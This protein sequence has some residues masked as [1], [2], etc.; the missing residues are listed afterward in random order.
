[1]KRLLLFTVAL[2]ALLALVLAYQTAARDREYRALLGHG[3]TAL[4]EDQTY[5]AIEAF[6]GAIALRPDSTIAHLRRGE[7]YRRRG[8]LAAAARDFRQAAE[9]DRAAVRP[10]EELGDVLYQQQKYALAADAYYRCLRID[11][12]Q[13]RVGYKLALARYR[14]RNLDG[15]SAAAVTAIRLDDHLA[16]AHYLLAL[17][18]RERNRPADALRELERAVALA[19]G[20]IATREELADLYAA[21]GRPADEL[22]QLQLLAGLDRDHPERQVALGLAQARM[23]H[24]DLAVLTL[25]SALER[26]PEEPRLY[27][28]LGRVWLEIAVGRDDPSALRKALAALQRVASDPAATSDVLTLYGRALARGGQLDAAEA[29][30]QQATGRLPAAPAAFLAYASIAGQLGH[31]DASRRALLQ[32]EALQSDD[33]EFVAHAIDIASLSTRLNDASTAVEWLERAARAAPADTHVLALLAEG[34]IKAGRPDAA[35]RTVAAG[36]EREPSNA[37]LQ[38]VARRLR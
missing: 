35:R 16:D 19:P 37:A 23:G 22:A 5:V 20:T 8:D 33:P 14:D 10:L 28:A 11:D 34:Q 15:A 2:A 30:L 12:R 1:M 13:P 32:Y 31:L 25:G 21:L 17:C 29:V 7:T 6:S 3:D 24:L 4:R 38:A 26:A 9:L 36:L 18:L 27:A